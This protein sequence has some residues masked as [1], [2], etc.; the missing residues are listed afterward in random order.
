MRC[1]KC[2]AEIASSDK[3]CPAC[4][5]AIPP[6]ARRKAKQVADPNQIKDEELGSWPAQVAYRCV[7][8]GLIP[9]AGLI[10]GPLAVGFGWAALRIERAKPG[11]GRKWTPFALILVGSVILLTNW[12]G[13]LMMAYGLWTSFTPH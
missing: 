13:V 9:L 5:Q 11:G 4:G 7:L 12:A 10:L 2:Q 3:T 6:G 1:P 8:Y